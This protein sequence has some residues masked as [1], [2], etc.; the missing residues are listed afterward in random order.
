MSTPAPCQCNTSVC[1]SNNYSRTGISDLLHTFIEKQV[2]KPGKEH[3]DRI[4]VL[5]PEY[6]SKS[7]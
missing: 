6:L 4:S 3:L 2:K 5:I 7:K 1:E